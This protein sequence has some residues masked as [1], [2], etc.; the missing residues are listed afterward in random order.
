M[1]DKIFV[2]LDTPYIAKAEALVKALESNVG[3][4]KLGLEFFTANG[5]EGVKRIKDLT[6]KAIFLDLKFHD[7]PNTVGKAARALSVIEPDIITVHASG[8]VDM[9]KAVKANSSSKTK[10]F[11]VTVLTSLPETYDS[12]GE[13]QSDIKALNKGL[14]IKEAGLDGLVCSGDFVKFGKWK[15]PE[16][17]FIVPGIRLEG[18]VVD[19]QKRT[20]T[21]KQ[22]IDDGADILVIGRPITDAECPEKALVKIIESLG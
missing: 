3:G 7:I 16:L 11:G 22:A 21:P 10:V 5:L 4:F 17:L 8:G 19:D 14:E 15:F 1:K 18:G 13:P 20:V 12:K 2:A 6:N 9:M